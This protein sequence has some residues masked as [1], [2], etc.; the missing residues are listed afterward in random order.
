MSKYNIIEKQG[1]GNIQ[2]KEYTICYQVN[3]KSN[4]YKVTLYCFGTD[5][6]KIGKFC[7]YDQGQKYGITT[8]KDK[9][10]FLE[11]L[12]LYQRGSAY[13]KTHPIAKSELMKYQDLYESKAQELNNIEQHINKLKAEELEN[14]MITYREEIDKPS[15]ISFE[16]SLKNLFKIQKRY[17]LIP[18]IY[19]VKNAFIIYDTEL[20]KAVKICI[21]TN[22]SNDFTIRELNDEELRY[23]IRYQ[24]N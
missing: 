23:F 20:K 8:N 18:Y 3:N 16:D 4:I 12:K 22:N 2:G 13:R 10:E 5:E 24:E 21:F 7:F 1:R 17:I 14:K 11:E 15:L 19:Y 6:G 9:T